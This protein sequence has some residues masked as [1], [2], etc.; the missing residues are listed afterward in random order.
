[1]GRRTAP[2]SSKKQLGSK[3]NRN[4]RS[5]LYKTKSPHWKPPYNCSKKISKGKYS[6][7]NKQPSKPKMTTLLFKLNRRSL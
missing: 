7:C 2:C 1:M 6:T 4:S 3:K 5:T